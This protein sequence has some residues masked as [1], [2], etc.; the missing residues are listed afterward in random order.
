M[1]CARVFCIRKFQCADFPLFQASVQNKNLKHDKRVMGRI[2]RLISLTLFYSDVNFFSRTKE[3]ILQ[4][5]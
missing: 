1:N 4:H 3:F 5:D 2:K